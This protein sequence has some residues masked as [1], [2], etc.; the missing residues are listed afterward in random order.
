MKKLIA[1]RPIQYLGRTYGPGDTLPAHDGRMVAAWERAGTA[2][3]SDTEAEQAEQR[4]AQLSANIQNV[5][6]ALAVGVL[7]A[8]G[9]QITDENGVF[10][11]VA[12]LAERIVAVVQEHAQEGAEGQ[13]G[14]EPGAG[15][16]DAQGGRED[17]VEGN[18]GQDTGETA[19][20]DGHLD[21]KQLERMT[22]A[23][24]LDLAGKL[25]VDLSG[26][27]NN[28]QRAA[29]IAAVEVQAPAQE[30]GGA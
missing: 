21:A 10:I 9:I 18:G 6:N 14:Q 12:Q 16:K 30:T 1:K 8:M 20:V 5:N 11:G 2:A 4:A 24:L 3:W 17:A 25:G 19:M 13:G 28:A 23:D 27:T 29:L 7:K 22:K 15:E 26:A